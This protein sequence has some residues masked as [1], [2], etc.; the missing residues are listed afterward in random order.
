MRLRVAGLGPD[1]DAPLVAVERRP[2]CCPLYTAATIVAGIAAL[3][4]V[5]RSGR[6]RGRSRCP[7]SPP[8]GTDRRRRACGPCSASPARPRSSAAPSG[9]GVLTF[10]LPFIVA[11]MVLGGPIAGGWVAFLASF[12]RRELREMPWYGALANHAGLALAAIVGGSPPKRPWRRRGARAAGRARGH[13]AR[14]RRRTLVSHRRAD[15]RSLPA[16]IVLRDGLTLRETLHVSTARSAARSSPRPSSAGCSSSPGSPSAGGRRPC[17]GARLA[18]WRTNAA[19]AERDRDELT[20]LLTGKAFAM[21]VAEAALRGRRGIEGAAYVFLDLDGFK[22]STTGRARMTSGDEVLAELGARLRRSIRITDAAGRRGGDEF[23]VLFVGVRDE[24][25]A[26]SLAERVHAL[27]TA[28]YAT[29]DG[30]KEVGASVG[31]ALIVPGE[32]DFEPDLRQRADEAMYDAKEAGGGV[33]AW[34]PLPAS[35]AGA[36]TGGPLTWPRP[37]PRPR[38]A[39]TSGPDPAI[40]A[41]FENAPTSPATTAPVA[42][43]QAASG[44]RATTTANTATTNTTSA[45]FAATI[46]NMSPPAASAATTG[47]ASTRRPWSRTMRTK[48]SASAPWA[49]PTASSIPAAAFG[50]RSRWG[51]PPSWRSRIASSLSDGHLRYTPAVQPNGVLWTVMPMKVGVARESAAGERRVALVP[52]GLGKLTAA[53]LEILVE[54]GAGAGAAIPDSAFTT[55][56]RRSSRPMSCTRQ[57][58]SSCASRSR[59]PPRRR[60]CA[61]ARP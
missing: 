49:L 39:G 17:R 26:L 36:G 42:M 12:E 25:T 5:T 48:V 59:R 55:P 51:M 22:R 31:I 23:M 24:A 6:S 61:A 44:C 52:E 46:A 15:R 35:R 60:A 2:R 21:R 33:R 40:T 29:S 1:P 50:V 4:L 10:H 7:G 11:A 16:S 53:G 54:A 20:G 37:P 13:A 47:F 14:R 41:T 30:P 9:H 19:E 32:R 57:P 18:L 3:R 34:R 56:A 27:V 45:A 8:R 43:K 38:A 28:P 58:T